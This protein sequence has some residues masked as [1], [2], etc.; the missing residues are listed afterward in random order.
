MALHVWQQTIVDTFGNIIP[1]AFVEV[2]IVGTGALAALY[3]DKDGTL[4]LVNPMT[5]DT[6]GF[7][8]FYTDSGMYRIRAYAGSTERIWEDFDISLSSTAEEIGEVT[9]DLT[10][11]EQ[12]AGLVG[13]N[14]IFRR[15]PGDLRRYG[16]VGDG[17]ADD[18]QAISD[19][20]AQCTLSGNPV[21]IPR[22]HTFLTGN[23]IVISNL[24][25]YGEGPTSKLKAKNSLNTHVLSVNNGQVYNDDVIFERFAID[26]NKANNSSGNLIYLNGRHCHVRSMHLSNS[27]NAAIVFGAPHSGGAQT[28]DA[29]HGSIVDN[30]CVSCGKNNGW[31][32]IAVTHGTDIVI[33]LNRIWNLDGQGHYGIDLEPN[34]CNKVYGIEVICNVIRGGQLL[35]DGK[36]I[37]GSAWIASHAYLSG[38][39]AIND[40]G[41]I[42]RCV[43]SG[44]S[45]ASGG[46][47]G[48]AAGITDGTVVWD[49]FGILSGA[50]ISGSVFANNVIDA[51][52]AYNA[53]NQTN[54][55]PIWI[56]QSAD[57]TVS[58]NNTYGHSSCTMGGLVI[59]SSGITTTWSLDGA[60][61]SNNTFRS[62]KSDVRSGYINKATDCQF[63]GNRWYV[64]TSANALEF[65]NCDDIIGT[66]NKIKNTGAGR[67]ITIGAGR[68]D[69]DES[70]KLIG[71]ATPTNFGTGRIALP[72]LYGSKTWDIGSTATQTSVQTQVTVTGV[73]RTKGNYVKSVVL[74]TLPQGWSLS[75]SITNT[76]E[77]TVTATNVT[78]STADPPSGTISV[79]VGRDIV[80]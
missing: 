4:P 68:V 80:A 72:D 31:G 25:I 50:T 76:D 33:A 14:F 9:N 34:A 57:L 41:K 62:D 23:I 40:S 43:T 38:Q 54:M 36:N 73:T 7:A 13:T 16:A 17:F 63:T 32:S 39:A 30:T 22:G 52:N 48:T 61:I 65:N 69:F 47:T 53:S 45:A 3:S 18:T 20:V 74:T 55:A 46:P 59:E 51:R 10:V 26:G 5:A 44:T 24:Q 75:G 58:C 15:L 60:S 71:G 27:A 21:F 1:E 12:S 56:R 70:N 6:E 29:G 78:G 11:P 77:V 67:A 66:G 49:F 42:Y 35:V 2:K 8:R 28:P 64:S 19:A 79:T 37:S